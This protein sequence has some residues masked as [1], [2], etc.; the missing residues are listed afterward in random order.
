MRNMEKCSFINL[1]V[2]GLRG[3]PLVDELC[4]GQATVPVSVGLLQQSLHLGPAALQ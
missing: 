4:Q 3:V 1:L 2:H